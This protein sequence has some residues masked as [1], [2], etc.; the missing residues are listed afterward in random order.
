MEKYNRSKHIDLRCIHA[1]VSQTDPIASCFV[2]LLNFG[3]VSPHPSNSSQ[4]R[5]HKSTASTN[6]NRVHV[7]FIS[8]IA[9]L[10]RWLYAGCHFPYSL[11]PLFM[12]CR[13]CFHFTQ[14]HRKQHKKQQNMH[15]EF[16]F[17]FLRCKLAMSQM[18]VI[19][20]SIAFN[21]ASVEP[22]NKAIFQLK[23]DFHLPNIYFL[24]S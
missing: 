3:F 5:D 23:H 19:Y 8:S 15:F 11:Y 2:S 17:L 16:D 4:P 21:T 10:H 12:A 7:V 24:A 13:V 6:I 18:W 14:N 20:T 1:K 22:T 9:Y